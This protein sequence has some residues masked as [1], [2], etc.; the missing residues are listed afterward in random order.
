MKS[1]LACV[2]AV[3]FSASA[4]PFPGLKQAA[5]PEVGVLL[6]AHGGEAAWNAEIEKI[7]VQLGEKY[8]VEVAL[9]MAENGPMQKAVDALQ[10]RRVKRIVAVPLFVSSWSEVMDQ[11][12]F[13]L[14]LR[15]KPSEA[16]MNAPHAHMMNHA[17]MQKIEFKVPFDLA[18]ALDDS[19]LIS[20]ILV[21]RAKAL[22]RDPSKESVLLVGHGP[23]VEEYNTKW[24]AT[25]HTHAERMQKALGFQWVEVATLRDDAPPAVREKAVKA[26]RDIVMRLSK[27]GK[28]LV[29]PLLIARGGIETK[30]PKDLDGT[31]FT[32]RGETLAPHP[33]L[34]RWAAATVE[35]QL[36]AAK[37]KKPAAKDPNAPKKFVPINN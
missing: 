27:Q 18:P 4:E 11:N 17:S 23:V 37:R 1:M 30:I 5:R 9:G 13:L 35:A 26:M 2:L 36:E 10:A 21:Q 20:D 28:V 6:L 12:R 16:L 25:M 31:F 22:S 32:W 15:D 33:N 34:E 8:A 29:I 7:K 24:L 3:A 14:G 19:P